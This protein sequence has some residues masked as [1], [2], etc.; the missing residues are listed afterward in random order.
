[1]HGFVNN[2]W[3][4][5]NLIQRKNQFSKVLHT[6][7]KG[8]NGEDTIKGGKNKILFGLYDSMILT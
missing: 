5:V 4:C 3:L 6:F 7:L 2:Q 8:Q 1:M